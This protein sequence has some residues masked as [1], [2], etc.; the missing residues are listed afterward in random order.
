MALGGRQLRMVVSPSSYSRTL[1]FSTGGVIFPSEAQEKL[2]LSQR[3]TRWPL[4]C[5][6]SLI[7]VMQLG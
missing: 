5:F 1:I 2:K 6:G 7:Q 4:Y 3:S